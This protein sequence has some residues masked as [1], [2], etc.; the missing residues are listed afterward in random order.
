[1]SVCVWGWDDGLGWWAYVGE[2]DVAVGDAGDFAGGAR[3]GLDADTVV[4]VD[5]LGVEDVDGVDGVV[6]PATDAADAQAVAAGAV[7]A[8]EGDLGTAVDGKAVILVVDSGAADGDLGGA[9]DV[10]SIGVVAALRVAVLVVDGDAVELGVGGGV[11]GEDLNGGVLDGLSQNILL[12]VIIA[13]RIVRMTYQTLDNGVGHGVSV[14]ELWLGLAA[15]RALGVPPASSITIDGSTS[16]VDSER[17]T[18]DGDQR[19]LPLL[20]SEGGS[21]LEDDMGAL[22]KRRRASQH[23]SQQK[24]IV[25]PSLT[26]A[27]LVK[28]RVLPAGTTRLSRVIVGQEDLAD[29]T[30]VAPEAPE[31]EQV[32]AALAAGAADAVAA[33]AT[34]ATEMIEPNILEESSK[35]NERRESWIG[36]RL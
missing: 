33:S 8:G 15:V 31:K 9:S 32:V 20:V 27:S 21:A 24:L 14:E 13:G 3:D 35:G 26:L 23:A 28:S 19:A 7:A 10:E 1:M 36:R 11:D 5:D 29:A 30:A 22:L 34:T 12:V 6:A 4:G 25:I 16:T 17:V 2:L 18:R